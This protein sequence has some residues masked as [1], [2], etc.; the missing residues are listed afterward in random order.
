MPTLPHRSYT[1]GGLTLGGESRGW[2]TGI[3]NAA[4]W[5]VPPWFAFDTKLEGTG[6]FRF[7]V[8]IS[9]VVVEPQIMQ[10]QLCYRGG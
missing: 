8:D 9:L 6:G 3:A 2:Y 1:V 5:A 4:S 7:A 10:T